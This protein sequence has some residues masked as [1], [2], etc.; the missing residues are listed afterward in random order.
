[1]PWP[2]TIP[3]TNRTDATVM[4]GTHPSDHNQLGLALADLRD[5]LARVITYSGIDNPAGSG[6]VAAH[7]AVGMTFTLTKS[8]LVKIDAAV[9]VAWATAFAAGDLATVDIYLNGAATFAQT[10]FPPA[11]GSGSGI[12]QARISHVV[13]LAAAAHTVIIRVARLSG[14]GSLAVGSV[15]WGMVTD[16]GAPAAS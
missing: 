2:P 16:L 1:M 5:N 7:T 14:A 13:T 9:G 6:V 10:T 3:P 15:G 12:Y 4:A 8:T 11:V